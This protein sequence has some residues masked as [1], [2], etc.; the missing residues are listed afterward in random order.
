MN[1]RKLSDNNL[2][3][4]GANVSA[5]LSG[6][7]LSAINAAVRTG[8]QTAI[9][10]LPDDLNAQ[11]MQAAVA[12]AGRKAVVSAKNATREQLIDRMAQVRNALLAPKNQF[13]LCGFDFRETTAGTVEAQD[14]TDLSAFGY[15]NGVNQLKFKGNNRAGTVVY[16]IWR[17]Q[18]DTGAWAL[19]STTKKQSF[20]DRA[21]DAGAVL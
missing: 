15:S 13:D 11:T 9:G 6:T 14:P 8:L 4:F 21:G 2:A 7:Q 1:Y 18:G 10:T 12:D 19:L 20:D 5:L 16:E 3:D 17:R